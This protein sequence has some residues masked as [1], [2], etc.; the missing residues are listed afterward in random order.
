M[1]FSLLKA[2]SETCETCHPDHYGCISCASGR[3]L[4]SGNCVFKCPT[5]YYADNSQRC[6]V[7]HDSCSSCIGPLSTQCTSCSFP[8]ALHLGQCLSACGEGFY[9]DHTTCKGCYSSCRECVGPEYLHC[10]RCM[11]A[12]EGLQPEMYLEGIPVGICLPQCKTQFYLDYDGVCK[13][14]QRDIPR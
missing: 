9:Q 6:R 5:G 7:C 14:E 10:T 4:H 13:G 3:V 11:K 12:E 1:I 2:C 8:L